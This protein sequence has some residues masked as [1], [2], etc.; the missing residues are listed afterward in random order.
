M[1]F[2]ALPDIIIL[3]ELLIGMIIIGKYLM[4]I[5]LPLDAEMVIGSIGKGTL[6]IARLDDALRQGDRGRYAIPAHLFHGVFCKFF[7]IL[8]T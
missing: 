2:I 1:V 8:L 5:V 3:L 4:T 6:F 7:D